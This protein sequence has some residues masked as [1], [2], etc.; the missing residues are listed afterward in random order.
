[1]SN[2]DYRL[3]ENREQCTLMR[4][5][6][7]RMQQLVGRGKKQSDIKELT[8]IVRVVDKFIAQQEKY[9][10]L[11]EPLA[12][13]PELSTTKISTPSTSMSISCLRKPNIQALRKPY[14]PTLPR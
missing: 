7:E 14:Q 12:L 4:L 5:N 8:R 13:Q 1:M 11:K 6:M 2:R 9:P 3:N 10:K